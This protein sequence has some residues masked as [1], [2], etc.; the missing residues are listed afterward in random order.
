MNY[1]NI[2]NIDTITSLGNLCYKV[3]CFDGDIFWVP[4]NPDNIDYLLVQ[5]WFAEHPQ[6]K[7]K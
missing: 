1:D 4:K 7:K 5:K 6:Q 3:I 2:K